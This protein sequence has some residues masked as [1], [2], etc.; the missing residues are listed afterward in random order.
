[1]KRPN[2]CATLVQLVHDFQ[3]GVCHFS[4]LKIYQVMHE[5]AAMLNQSSIKSFSTL[6]DPK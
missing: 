4:H 5:T 3:N 6:R 1:M 2:V